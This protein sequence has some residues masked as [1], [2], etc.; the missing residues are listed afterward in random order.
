MIGQNLLPFFPFY[1]RGLSAYDLMM[2]LFGSFV[3]GK[4]PF[5]PWSFITKL[6][7][8]GLPGN[9]MTDCSMAFILALGSI[10]IRANLKKYLGF[11]PKGQNNPFMPNLDDWEEKTNEEGQ[12]VVVT[13]NITEVVERVPET[14]ILTEFLQ[15]G[16]EIQED[17][18]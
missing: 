5:V 13:N 16:G 10:S 6:S 4:I 9:D 18:I 17:K 14:I 11:G 15:E 8:R 12:H 2:F 7:H 1:D 3:V